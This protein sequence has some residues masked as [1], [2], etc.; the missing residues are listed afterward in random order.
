M[1]CRTQISR[2]HNA[3]LSNTPQRRGANRLTQA[4]PKCYLTY[5]IHGLQ[6]TRRR[7]AA[8]FASVLIV[9]IWFRIVIFQKIINGD[10]KKII[11]ISRKID[12]F[13]VIAEKP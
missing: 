1:I 10:P 11:K 5:R 4:F 2:H 8:L 6:A 9:K 13:E 3:A 12:L 7:E